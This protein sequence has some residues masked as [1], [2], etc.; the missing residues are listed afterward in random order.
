MLPPG[1]LCLLITLRAKDSLN[2]GSAS[3]HIV[4]E[5][6]V[7]AKLCP[8]QAFLVYPHFSSLGRKD[9]EGL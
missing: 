2:S 7:I 1:Y 8:K 6:H 3:V 9:I 4:I 5:A